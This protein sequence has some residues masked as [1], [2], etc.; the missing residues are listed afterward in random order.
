MPCDVSSQR[1]TDQFLVLDNDSSKG[2]DDSAP[3]LKARDPM[4]AEH[5]AVLAHTS[6][7]DSAVYHTKDPQTLVRKTLEHH[8]AELRNAIHVANMTLGRHR[9]QIKAEATSPKCE[10]ENSTT[11]YLLVQFTLGSTKA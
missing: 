9:R 5:D 2:K 4:S 10:N 3:F 1:L 8:A 6:A 7:A 11:F